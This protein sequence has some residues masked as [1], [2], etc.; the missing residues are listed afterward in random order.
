[1]DSGDAIGGHLR[2]SSGSRQ[3]ITGTERS[4]V[5][6]SAVRSQ[7]TDGVLKTVKLWKLSHVSDKM[8]QPIKKLGALSSLRSMS[9]NAIWHSSGTGSH[10]GMNRYF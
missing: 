3:L 7:A 8:A 2:K 6:T 1:M 5:H 4:H 10:I 9:K